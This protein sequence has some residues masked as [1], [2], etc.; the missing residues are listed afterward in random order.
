MHMNKTIKNMNTKDKL[1]NNFYKEA[2][3]THK[4]LNLK[5]INQF[6]MKL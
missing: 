2:K 6:S 5:D 3:I 4:N 1:L